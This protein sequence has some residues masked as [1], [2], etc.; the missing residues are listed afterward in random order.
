[1]LI[2]K[3]TS[4]WPFSG[5]SQALRKM[6]FAPRGSAPKSEALAPDQDQVGVGGN[7]RRRGAEQRARAGGVR[8]LVGA[9]EEV[10][11]DASPGSGPAVRLDE[12]G[13]ARRRA[14]P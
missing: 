13:E 11:G 2:G 3:N 9:D 4:A 6:I 7:A 5:C 1:M 10:V 8:V 12:R 14:P